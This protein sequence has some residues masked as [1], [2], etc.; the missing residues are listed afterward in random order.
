MMTM[1]TY[2]N[3]PDFKM[4]SRSR[5]SPVPVREQVQSL[6]QVLIEIPMSVSTIEFVHHPT[7]LSVLY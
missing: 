5:C 2:M 6:N 7:Y 3:V 1:I 4:H